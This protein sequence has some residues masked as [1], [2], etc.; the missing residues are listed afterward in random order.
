MNVI[1]KRFYSLTIIA[2]L[3]ISL[4]SC[5]DLKEEVTINSDG[6]GSFIQTID[7]GN[8]PMMQMALSMQ[9]D[10]AKNEKKGMNKMDSTLEKTKAK[11]SKVEGIS[12]VKTASATEGMKYTVMYDFAD[13]DALNRALN[14]AKDEKEGEV[15]VMQKQYSFKKGEL[16]RTNSFSMG[17]NDLDMS[18]IM[19]GKKGEDDKEQ[20][21]E[22]KKQTQQMMQMFFGDANYTYIVHV[23]NKVKS[24]SN[25]KNTTVSEDG[26]TLTMTIP[27]LDLMNEE[28]KVNA[29]NAVK[30]K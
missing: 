20:T 6:S 25:K 18:A 19:G 3:A 7:M 26:K 30:F 17:G 24:Y 16:T 21:E 28:K 22:E 13:I 4:T 8:N 27:L 23:P 11:L 12:N 15:K 29:G 2:I 14:A 9:S 5:F 10:S 1:F